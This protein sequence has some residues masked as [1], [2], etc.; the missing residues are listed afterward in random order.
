MLYSIL[1]FLFQLTVKGYFRS[2][3]VLG[4]EHI[5]DTGP[6]IFV[7]NHPS[8]FMD[9]I[10][11]STE[12]NRRLFFLAR[13]D[14]FDHRIASAFFRLINMIPV[15]RK[16]ETPG[17]TDRNDMVFQKCFEH[18][19]KGKTL[20]IFPEGNSK[21]ERKLRSLKTG[22]A[23][24]AIGAELF[25]SFRLGVKIVPIG[26]NYTNP[27]NFRS[28]VFINFGPPIEVVE[29]KEIYVQDDHR[30]VI[31]LTEHI[32]H[33]L[34]KL[35][36]I[37]QNEQLEELVR[38]IEL[39]YRSKLR[40]SMEPADK[41]IQDFKL[42]KDIVMALNYHIKRDP[43][44]V[45]LF[46]ANIAAYLN[47]LKELNIRDSQVRMSHLNIDLLKSITYFAAG[48][49][50]FVFGY[51]TNYLPFKL[52]GWVSSKVPTR[53]D[54]VGSIKIAAGMLIFL[55]LY[56][57][58]ALIVGRYTNIGWAIIFILSLYPAGVFTLN[59]LK[60]YFQM[61]GTLKYLRLFIQKSDLVAKLKITRQQLID[62]LEAGKVEYLLNK[63]S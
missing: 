54:F 14:I 16:G 30:G 48:M 2:I 20:L 25:N 3:T 22:T 8:A 7:A 19:S 43:E 11:L 63:D 15:Y 45:E 9:P 53:G 58:E 17:H 35:L 51:I 44:K 49:P 1:R 55:I 5:P 59:Y 33:E 40:E 28:D 4:K 21:T 18:L 37:V 46:Q 36:V 32:R 61:I 57:L 41:G 39:L 34:E 47:G 6:V 13:G 10:L 24:I 42:S 38:Q 12:V 29:Y 56:I 31:M 50:M 27:H 52:A 62:E 23:R 60:R 26:I